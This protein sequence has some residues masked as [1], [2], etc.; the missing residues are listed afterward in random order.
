MFSI[1]KEHEEEIAFIKAEQEFM[2][3]KTW[4]NGT[5]MGEFRQQIRDPKKLSN[6]FTELENL[7]I[8]PTPI[9]SIMKR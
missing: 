8:S 7:K 6:N 9:Q 1:L 3:K 4:R 5:R 2:G